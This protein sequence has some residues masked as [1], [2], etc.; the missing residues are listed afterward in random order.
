MCTELHSIIVTVV[1]TGSMAAMCMCPLCTASRVTAAQSEPRQVMHVCYRCVL[2]L[3][4]R[5]AKAVAAG[6]AADLAVVQ[7][8]Q[9][10][11]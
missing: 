4:L 8:P 2:H 7:G 3:F 6:A 5:H 1:H 9:G 11:F 10:Q